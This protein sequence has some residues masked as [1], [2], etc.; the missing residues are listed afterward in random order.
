MI[1][2]IDNY[3]NLMVIEKNSFMIMLNSEQLQGHGIDD[4]NNVSL[5]EISALSFFYMPPHSL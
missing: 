4:D 3:V 5:D 1:L 2:D